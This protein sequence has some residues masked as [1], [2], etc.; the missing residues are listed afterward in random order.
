M[1]WKYEFCFM[2]CDWRKRTAFTAHNNVEG[3]TVQ[4]FPFPFPFAFTLVNRCIIMQRFRSLH[5]MLYHECGLNLT[6]AFYEFS[7]VTV[8]P[9]V[10]E[11]PVG[12]HRF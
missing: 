6:Y 1:T 10:G 9:S 7:C 5:S 3:R 12:K 4:T 8:R 11:P 2:I